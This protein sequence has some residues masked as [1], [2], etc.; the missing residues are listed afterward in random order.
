MF[1]QAI[2]DEGLRRGIAVEAV[3]AEMKELA[4]SRDGRR[5]TTIQSLSDLTSAIAFRRCSDKIHSRRVLERPGLRVPVARVVTFDQE[6]LAFLDEWKEIVVK[7]ASGK[8][9]AGVTAPCST[10]TI[11]PRR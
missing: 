2:A 6:E 1:S 5:V 7:P 8:Q 4:L 10:R 3:D 11:G 9:G